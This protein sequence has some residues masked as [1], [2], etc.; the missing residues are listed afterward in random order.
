MIIRTAVIATALSLMC[1]VSS[2]AQTVT[3]KSGLWIV[4]NKSELNGKKMPGILDIK[5]ISE[6]EKQRIRNALKSMGMPTDWNP[7]FYCQQSDVIDINDVL[8]KSQADCPNPS[9][10]VNGSKITYTA[11]CRTEQGNAD[12]SGSITIVS[13]TESKSNMDASINVQGQQLV[14]HQQELSKWIGSDCNVPP[15]GI[16]PTWIQ[17]AMMQ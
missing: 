1:S 2:F 17:S 4:S 6:S 13:R 9:V 11:K 7:S 5:G 16:D 10:K 3:T 14:M 12:V 15:K 8:R